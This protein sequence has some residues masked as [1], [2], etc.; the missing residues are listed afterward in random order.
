[1]AIDGPK[2]GRKAAYR[3]G[4]CLFFRFDEFVRLR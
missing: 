4:K 2:M 1:M 3:A